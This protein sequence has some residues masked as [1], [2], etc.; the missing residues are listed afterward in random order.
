MSTADRI[1]Q[2][3]HEIREHDR[4][5][6]VDA[7]PSISDREYDR[8][9]DKLKSL[10]AEHPELL[11]NDSP[12]QRVAGT[13]IDG[14]ETVNHARPMYSIDNSY[15]ADE[16]HKWADRLPPEVD[17]FLIDPKIDGVAISLRYEEGHLVLAATRGDGQQG[18]DVT[19]KRPHHSLDSVVAGCQQHSPACGAR[20]TRRGLLSPGRCSRSGTKNSKRK[21]S[22]N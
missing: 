21:D 8:L 3:R 19:Q 14:F 9:L 7:T 1:E 13:P 18:D 20:S 12:T 22:S 2:L 4:R 10:E 16:L 5:Y 15:A 6:Y 11:T 17:R